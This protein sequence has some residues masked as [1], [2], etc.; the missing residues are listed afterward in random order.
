[1]LKHLRLP[2]MCK[3]FMFKG[4]LVRMRQF[5]K[6]SSVRLASNKWRKLQDENFTGYAYTGQIF[7]M[8]LTCSVAL[9]ERLR[10]SS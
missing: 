2:P 4:T 9:V 10:R 3:G 1:M 8:A 5:V 7:T 6:S